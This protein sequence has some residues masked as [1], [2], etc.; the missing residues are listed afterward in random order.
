MAQEKGFAGWGSPGNSGRR[1]ERGP[2]DAVDRPQPDD[3]ARWAWMSF[4][5]FLPALVGTSWRDRAPSCSQV[6]AV[7]RCGSH[8]AASPGRSCGK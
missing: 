6:T 7:K 2:S 5:A 8:R 4:Y 3:L 1:W